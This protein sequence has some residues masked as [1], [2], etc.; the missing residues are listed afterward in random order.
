MSE[1]NDDLVREDEGDAMNADPGQRERQKDAAAAEDELEGGGGDEN[2]M[3]DILGRGED[4]V[5]S[6]DM[7]GEGDEAA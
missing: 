5:D 6:S 4:V 7:A 2:I 1:I 3:D